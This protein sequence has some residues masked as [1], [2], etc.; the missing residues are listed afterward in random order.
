MLRGRFHREML[1][2]DAQID[3]SLNETEAQRRDETRRRRCLIEVHSRLIDALGGS[4]QCQIANLPD[5]LHE[6]QREKEGDH[7]DE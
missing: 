1:D 6:S 5:T 3:F 4:V 7:E 2:S